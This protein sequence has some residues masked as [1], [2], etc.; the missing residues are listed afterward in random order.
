LA[1]TVV[2]DLSTDE[3]GIAITRRGRTAPT[4]HTGVI[5]STARDEMEDAVIIHEGM[6]QRALK[7]RTAVL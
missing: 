5:R 1:D 7:V 6:T 2:V 4:A 3:H